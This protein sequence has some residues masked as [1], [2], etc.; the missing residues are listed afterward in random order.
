MRERDRQRS[1]RLESLGAL[2]GSIAHDLNNML[3][4]VTMFLE[5]LKEPRSRPSPELVDSVSTGVGRSA[6]MLRQLLTF[7][8]GTTVERQPLP[9]EVLLSD[10]GQAVAL[11]CPQSIEFHSMVPPDIWMIRGDAAQL[12]QMLQALCANAREA[13]PRGGHLQV[14][15]SNLQVTEQNATQWVGAERGQHVL[16]EVTDTG[17]GIAPEYLDRIFEPFFTTKSHA[18]NAEIGRAHV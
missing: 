6:E 12:H 14:T 15:A 11:S 10:V 17:T 18:R 3:T 2:A 5:E 16:I 4:P 7:G 9:V 13:M 8:R 1:E